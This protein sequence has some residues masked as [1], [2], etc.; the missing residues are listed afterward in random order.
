M[1]RNFDHNSGNKFRNNFIEK[2]IPRD[3]LIKP[4]LMQKQVGNKITKE[5]IDKKIHE[6]TYL[7]QKATAN[8]VKTSISNQFVKYKPKNS[9]QTKIIRIQEY[10]QDPFCPPQYKSK[11]IP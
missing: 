8:Q 6:I 4:S 9:K 5:T 3:K 11:R 1:N 7:S 10:Q 2:Y